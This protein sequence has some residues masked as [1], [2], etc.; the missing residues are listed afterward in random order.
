[1]ASKEDGEVLNQVQ[2]R[3]VV[4]IPPLPTEIDSSTYM[5]RVLCA[6]CC[7]RCD[8]ETLLA[9]FL[10]IVMRMEICDKLHE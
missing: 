5:V 4:N 10:G 2:A 1:V 9:V 6:V 3:F 8:D 7:V